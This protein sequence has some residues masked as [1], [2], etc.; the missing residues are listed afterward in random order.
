MAERLGSDTFLHVHSD[1]IGPLTVRAGGDVG[2][3][4][5]DTIYLTPDPAKVH[6]FGPDGKAIGR[7]SEE[8]L[9]GAAT[10][11]HLQTRAACFTLTQPTRRGCELPSGDH[12]LIWSCPRIGG[13]P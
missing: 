11:Q 9:I 10:V 4:H 1:E 12:R 6:R 5:G 13:E 2:A 3:H 8:W 7:V